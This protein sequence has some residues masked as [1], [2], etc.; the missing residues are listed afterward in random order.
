MLKDVTNSPGN[1]AAMVGGRR[2][3]FQHIGS[4]LQCPAASNGQ[5]V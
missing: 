2:M 1:C 3:G 4:L 5:R